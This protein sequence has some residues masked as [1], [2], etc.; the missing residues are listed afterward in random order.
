MIND[1]E[2]VMLRVIDQVLCSVK[3]IPE[4]FEFSQFKNPSKFEYK[5]L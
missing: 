1:V 2:S 4:G 3:I 5:T